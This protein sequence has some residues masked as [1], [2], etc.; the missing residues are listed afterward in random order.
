ME[1]RR[2]S[3]S[4][5]QGEGRGGL[6]GLL[7][8]RSGKEA[9]AAE[10]APAQWLRLLSERRARGFA[11]LPPSL[12]ISPRVTEVESGGRSRRLQTW[13][14]PKASQQVM[15]LKGPAAGKD[16][17][18]GDVAWRLCQQE[19]PPREAMQKIPW[20]GVGKGSGLVGRSWGRSLSAGGLC[21]A[22]CQEPREESPPLLMLQTLIAHTSGV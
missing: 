4:G 12:L 11:P 14:G 18:G 2:K 19:K 6:S 17:G 10:P 21:L 9:I 20:R 1:K 13:R 5:R 15:G 22:G 3:G 16:G 7:I 8:S